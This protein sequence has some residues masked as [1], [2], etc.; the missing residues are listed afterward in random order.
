ML[1]YPHIEHLPSIPFTFLKATLC[2]LHFVSRT[3]D[4]KIYSCCLDHASSNFLL[5]YHPAG[6]IALI[7]ITAGLLIKSKYLLCYLF[8]LIIEKITSSSDLRKAV[9]LIRCEVTDCGFCPQEV[10]VIPSQLHSK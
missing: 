9:R 5:G 10:P 3:L 8:F 7:K 2:F 1:L 4:H 6:K